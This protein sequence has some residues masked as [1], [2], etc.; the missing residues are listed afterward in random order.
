MFQYGGFHH[1]YGGGY[2]GYGDI[3]RSGFAQVSEAAT[4]RKGAMPVLLK[5]Y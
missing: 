3:D 1:A 5:N 4:R 2:G